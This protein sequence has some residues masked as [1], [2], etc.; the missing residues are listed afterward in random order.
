LGLLGGA[1]TQADPLYQ[2]SIITDTLGSFS[3]LAV[4]Y[5]NSDNQFA[6]FPL[7]NYSGGTIFKVLKRNTVGTGNWTSSLGGSFGGVILF[8]TN[9]LEIQKDPT[10][11]QADPPIPVGDPILITASGQ[12][13]TFFTAAFNDVISAFPSPVSRPD[14]SDFLNIG[15]NTGQTGND[16]SVFEFLIYNRLLNSSEYAQV[17]NYLKTKYQYSSW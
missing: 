10:T 3:G 6:S 14:L 8:G 11:Y 5:T 13:P 17:V 16:T 4:N 12:S 1:I 9:P 15:D 2:P 7:E